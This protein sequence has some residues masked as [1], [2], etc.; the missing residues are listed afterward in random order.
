MKYLILIA[1]SISLASV[2]SVNAFGQSLYVNPDEDNLI[3]IKDSKYFA[4]SIN[5]LRNSNGELISVVKTEASRYLPNPITDQFIDTLPIM[6]EG[7]FNTKNI[8]MRQVEVN[9]NYEKCITEMY[10]VPGYADQCN[11]YHRAYVTSLGINN[12]KDERFEIFRGL[13]HS[14]TVKPSDS[15]TSFW[16]IIRSD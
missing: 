14:Y 15:V 7:I 1:I 2:F 10:Q 3:K 16:T 12:D 8:E 6:K 11:W 13:N 9:Y 5:V 4:S